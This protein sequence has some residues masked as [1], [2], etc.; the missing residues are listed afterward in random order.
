[1]QSAPIAAAKADLWLSDWPVQ[2]LWFVLGSY[3]VLVIAFHRLMPS[4]TPFRI[5]ELPAQDRHLAG[6]IGVA[7]SADG[8]HGVSISWDRTLKLWDLETRCV[9]RTLEDTLGFAH[10]VGLSPDARRAVAASQYGLKVWDLT[11]ASELHNINV[12]GNWG[13]SAD[14]RRAV[15]DFRCEGNLQVWDLEGGHRLRD[16]GGHARQVTSL[17]VNADG[18][19]AVSA[20]FDEA[21]KLWDLD[22][23]C[24]LRSLKA[25]SSAVA[26]VAITPDGCRAVAAYY[27]NTVTVWNLAEGSEL[28]KLDGHASPA[29]CLGVSANGRLAVSASEDETLRWW[30]LDNG[31]LL[32]TFTCGA[33][34]CS[35]VFIAADKLIAGDRGGGIHFLCLERPR[36]KR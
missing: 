1:M 27:D 32:A 10:G 33:R 2:S 4:F 28:R 31:L 16:L 30:D 17:A 11:N 13:V 25:R 21:L 9:L 34:M 15:V 19:R 8:R 29:T 20:C 5:F 24:E 18:R 3:S 26:D 12:F 36:F 7:I 22:S 14:C 23:G 35:C 6:V